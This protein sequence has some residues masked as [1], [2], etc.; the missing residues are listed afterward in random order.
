MDRLSSYAKRPVAFLLRYVRRRALS[1]AAILAAVIGLFGIAAT[2]L[3]AALAVTAL[4]ATPIARGRSASRAE[5]GDAGSSTRTD[6]G[7]T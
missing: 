6:D 4:Q 2:G 1:H 3:V 7:E 5:V